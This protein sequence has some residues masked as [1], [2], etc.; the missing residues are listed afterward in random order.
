MKKTVKEEQL[1][2]LKNINKFVV[3]GNQILNFSK[4]HTLTYR[5]KITLE[6]MIEKGYDYKKV[7]ELRKEFKNQSLILKEL[8]EFN[9]NACVFIKKDIIGIIRKTKIKKLLLKK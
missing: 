4:Y 5:G 9:G 7:G 3:S 8:I 6:I 1:E 2:I